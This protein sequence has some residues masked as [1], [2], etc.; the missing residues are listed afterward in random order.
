MHVR[1][2]GKYEDLKWRNDEL[3]E[4]H[5]LH[6]KYLKQWRNMND[7]NSLEKNK[8]LSKLLSVINAMYSGLKNTG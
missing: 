8:L 2:N 7:E 4:L 6:I 3:V 1:R 5:H